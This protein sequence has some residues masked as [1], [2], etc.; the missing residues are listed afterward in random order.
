[1]L[2]R[3]TPSG[4]G[5]DAVERTRHPEPRTASR[6]VLLMPREQAA[7]SSYAVGLS[8]PEISARVAF[9]ASLTC[10]PPCSQGAAPL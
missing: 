10:T 2:G 4:S 9:S 3:P 8:A 6:W 5:R 7:A 1:M